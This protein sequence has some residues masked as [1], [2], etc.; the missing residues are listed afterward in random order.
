MLWKLFEN[1]VVSGCLKYWGRL[2]RNTG[3]L[4]IRVRTEPGTIT[5]LPKCLVMI[6][7]SQSMLRYLDG[8]V[9]CYMWFS[10]CLSLRSHSQSH[11]YT[12]YIWSALKKSI[13]SLESAPLKFP[14]LWVRQMVHS[15]SPLQLGS[16]VFH[17][18]WRRAWFGI[19]N[20]SM[21]WTQRL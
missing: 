21:K 10:F 2:Q 15:S 3:D 17:S 12:C 9:H 4:N 11:V 5:S 14:I 1:W 18:C 20:V 16:G 6:R 13:Q 19:Y 7:I 8:Y